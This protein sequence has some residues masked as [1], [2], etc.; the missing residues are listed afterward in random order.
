MIRHPSTLVLLLLFGILPAADFIL[1]Q[2]LAIGASLPPIII[3]S[4]LAV[5]LTIITGMIGLLHLGI[6]AMMAIGAYAFSILS[7]SI[8][9]F[10]IGFWSALVCAGAIAGG[11]GALLLAPTV[12]L[13]GDYIAIVTL[14][15]GE[16]VQDT[17]RNVDVITKGTQGINPLP[18]PSFFGEALSPIGS[19]YVLLAL[20]AVAVFVAHRLQDSYVGRSWIALRED[21]LAAQHMGILAPRERLRV[22]AFGSCL[23]GLSGALLAAVLGSS[24]EPSNYDFQVSI[25]ALAMVIVGGIGSIPGALIGAFV[26]VGIN[27]VVLGK[28]SEL[29]ASIGGNSQHVLLVP[30]N[31]KYLIFGLALVVM[32][33]VKRDGLLPFIALSQEK[34]R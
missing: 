13:R 26:M 14:G 33:R 19:Y 27:S 32:M 5:G 1:P 15:F 22:V 21:E 28:A 4:L 24:G 16:I 2:N 10:Q 9:P 17:L 11:T 29:I 25:M 31:W 23:A 34:H 6:A 8:Y 12:R 3:F 30:S 18:G 20:L 7:T